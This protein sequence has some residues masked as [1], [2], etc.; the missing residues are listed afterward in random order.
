MNPSS[1]GNSELEERGGKGMVCILLNKHH[2]TSSLH[3]IPIS[4]FPFK[5]AY[6]MK[7]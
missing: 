3:I 2:M 1:Y 4:P 6:G 5:N 7:K